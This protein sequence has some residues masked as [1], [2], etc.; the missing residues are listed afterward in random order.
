[1][2]RKF[3]ESFHL[4]KLVTFQVLEKSVMNI[5]LM[6]MGGMTDGRNDGRK[7]WWKDKAKP[8]Y[9]YFFKE[10]LQ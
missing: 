4:Y 10:G 9:P 2:H 8:V 5:Y 3:S 1:M 7:E 6:R